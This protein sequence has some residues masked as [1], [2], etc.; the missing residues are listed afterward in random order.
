M[1]V[2]ST[3]FK[4]AF[5]KYLNVALEGN[6]VIITKNGKGVAKLKR[7]TEVYPSSIKEEAAD[8]F[9]NKRIS[10]EEFQKICENSDAR[11]ELI[12]GVIY[13]LAAP[14]H[15]HQIAV[16]EL[17]VQLYRYFEDKSCTALTSPYD[18]KL[19]N[20]SECFKDDP[21]VVQPDLLVI[22]DQENIINNRYEGI[23]TLVIEVLSPSTRRKDIYIKSQL[24]AKS[25]VKEY[26]IVDLKA[27]S[28]LQYDLT[29]EE[30]TFAKVHEFGQSFNSFYFKDLIIHTD[31]LLNLS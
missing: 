27:Q 24:Y 12:D 14:S 29:L 22:C 21:N 9:V 1:R 31:K 23:P 13:L 20:D 30:T 25:G 15:S 11:Y 18:V 17:L 2:P 5:G 6:E 4:N 7:Y 3:K 8:Y 26:W 28:I 16:T 19:Y 10:Y